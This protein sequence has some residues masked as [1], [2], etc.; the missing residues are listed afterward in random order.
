MGKFCEH[1]SEKS[2]D[3]NFKIFVYNRVVNIGCFPSIFFKLKAGIDRTFLWKFT[4]DDEII[5]LRV[6]AAKMVFWWNLI[7]LWE[8]TIFATN[9]LNMI[10]SSSLVNVSTNVLPFPAFYLKKLFWRKT[11]YIWFLTKRKFSTEILKNAYLSNL[12]RF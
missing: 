2:R 3:Q 12:H 8:K 5:I 11:P 6:F 9:T 7:Y 10:I 1:S 4:I